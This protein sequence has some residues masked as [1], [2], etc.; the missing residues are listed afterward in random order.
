MSAALL[1]GHAAVTPRYPNG[2]SRA[3]PYPSSLLA[4]PPQRP[5]RTC[6]VARSLNLDSLSPQVSSPVGELLRSH[7]PEAEANRVL[8]LCPELASAAHERSHTVIAQLLELELGSEDLAKICLQ[9]P[10]VRGCGC[11][12]MGVLLMHGCARMGMQIPAH[13]LDGHARLMA[14]SRGHQSVTS[15]ACGPHGSMHRG[16]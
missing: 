2:R 10:Q 9:H 6:T 7:M 15:G 11:D 4:K 5:D 3:R 13:C 14:N 12:S 16:C 1:H 8:Q